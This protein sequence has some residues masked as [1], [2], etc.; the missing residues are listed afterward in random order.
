MRTF[1]IRLT[2]SVDSCT[3]LVDLDFE[4]SPYEGTTVEGRND[5]DL[6]CGGNGNEQIFRI[7]ILSG[8]T[9]TI[10]QSKNSFD[11][12]HELKVGSTCP[13]EVVI[14]CFDDPVTLLYSS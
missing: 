1:G 5:F 10:G 8:Q 7:T 4:I 13:G 9:I 2:V 6:S 11:S 3:E 14:E 12:R